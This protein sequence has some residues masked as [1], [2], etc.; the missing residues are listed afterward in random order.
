MKRKRTRE[1]QEEKNDNAEARSL[2]APSLAVDP[3]TTTPQDLEA[4][5]RSKH[6]LNLKAIVDTVIVS[7]PTRP[8]DE[9]EIE[10]VD[11]REIFVRVKQSTFKCRVCSVEEASTLI[12]NKYSLEKGVI[13]DDNQVAFSLQT[14]LPAGQNLF[15]EGG[16]TGCKSS[17]IFVLIS[18]FLNQSDL[19]KAEPVLQ[20]CPLES[21]HRKDPLR[22]PSNIVLKNLSATIITLVFHICFS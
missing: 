7:G 5:Q 8:P 16:E 6:N 20:K 12:R 11:L 9:Q 2:P 19:Q 17:H 21:V 4:G 14:I 1:Q 10:T 22:R 13:E 18:L 15:F 3:T